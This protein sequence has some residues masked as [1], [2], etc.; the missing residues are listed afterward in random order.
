MTGV[1]AGEVEGLTTPPGLTTPSLHPGVGTP[2]LDMQ[3]S[4]NPESG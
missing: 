2:S 1:G 3:E 4:Q